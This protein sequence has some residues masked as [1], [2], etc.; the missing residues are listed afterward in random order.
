MIIEAYFWNKDLL[1]PII[2]EDGKVTDHEKWY[3]KEIGGKEVWD[4]ELIKRKYPWMGYF[5]DIVAI[6]NSPLPNAK[7]ADGYTAADGTYHLGCIE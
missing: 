7:T 4:Q 2:D 6:L 5:V 1:I 3:E